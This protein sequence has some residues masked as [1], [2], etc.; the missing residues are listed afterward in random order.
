M[1]G[2]EAA[3]RDTPLALLGIELKVRKR[4][5]LKNVR[6][7]PPPLSPPPLCDILIR[8]RERLNVPLRPDRRRGM[9]GGVSISPDAPDSPPRT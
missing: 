6:S 8:R 9:G 5:M 3:P 1:D 7:A 4:E 2:Y